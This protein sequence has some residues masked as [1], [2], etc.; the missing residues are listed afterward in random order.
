M[1]SKRIFQSFLF[2]LAVFLS[3]GCSKDSDGENLNPNLRS[4]IT[5]CESLNSSVE[6]RL[7]VSLL[8]LN[9]GLG[10]VSLSEANAGDIDTFNLN[11]NGV[12]YSYSVTERT[13]TISSSTTKNYSGLIY[14]DAFLEGQTN[15]VEVV[16]NG[17]E[18]QLLINGSNEDIGGVDPNPPST[19]G[20]WQRY[21]SPS[22]Y[23]TDLAIGNI[24]GQPE[25]RVYMCEHPGSP[26]AGLYK[27]TI[28]GTT[29]TWD[30]VHNLPNAVFNLLG[31]GPDRTLYFGVGNPSDAGKYTLGVWTGTCPL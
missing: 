7:T 12:D 19:Y 18:W 13:G 24:P 10:T 15:I 30:A 1:I 11:G 29:I 14:D 20:R 6:Y 4:F 17:E 28:E 26:S 2:V 25:N 3:N 16:R 22:G 31:S 8:N 23:Q 21:G 5:I 9:D 27:G